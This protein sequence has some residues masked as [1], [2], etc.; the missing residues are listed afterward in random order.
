MMHLRPVT[1]EVKPDK[2][3]LVADLVLASSSK[4]W[5]KHEVQGPPQTETPACAVQREGPCE[6]MRPAAGILELHRVSDDLHDALGDL[7]PRNGTQT[8]GGVHPSCQ[9]KA[10]GGMPEMGQDHVPQIDQC[11]P[12]RR[13]LGR[14]LFQNIQPANPISASTAG[15]AAKTCANITLN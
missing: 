8:S 6:N 14:R 9:R 5:L 15:P 11:A 1:V 10:Q 13:V 2:R 7:P 4:P 3:N 12:A